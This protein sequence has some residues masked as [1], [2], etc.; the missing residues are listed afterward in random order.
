MAGQLTR[1]NLRDIRMRLYL[2]V[3][4]IFLSIPS[5]NPVKLTSEVL[6]FPEESV[7]ALGAL[8]FLYIIFANGKELSYYAL[9]IFFHS[10]LNIFFSSIEVLGREN[11]PQHGPI[12]FSGNHMNQ[13]VDGGVA[14]I[15]CPHKLNFLVAASSFKMFLIGHFARLLS[16]LP[17]HRPIDNAKQAKGKIY[18]EGLKCFGEGT[19]F[20]K[21]S[22]KDKIRPSNT[23]NIYT[24]VQVESDTVCI[25]GNDKGDPSPIDETVCKGPG[26]AVK[27]ETLSFVD[28]SGTFSEVHTALQK[29]ESII[30][31]P[32]GGSHDNT[33]LLPLK[34]GVASIAFGTLSDGNTNVSIVPFGLN[35]FRGDRFRGKVV[36]EY[37]EPIH[38]TKELAQKYKENKREAYRDLLS[39][40]A[41]GMRS[42]LVT[43]ENYDELK[44]IHTARRLY[45]RAGS[46]AIMTTKARQ[47]LA[48]RFSMALRILKERYKDPSDPDTTVP[49]DLKVLQHKLDEYQETLEKWGIYDYQVN[50]LDISFSK[51]L[52]VFLHGFI[53][54][55]VASIPSVL[56]NLPVGFAAKLFAE[57]KRTEALAKS[58][59]KIAATDVLQSNKIIFSIAA[60]PFLWITYA[61]LLYFF[62]NWQLKTIVLSFL[63]F[64]IF[65]YIGIKS[66]ETSMVDL[67]DLRP[68]FLRLFPSFR[69]QAVKIP[70]QRAEV[71]KLV[72]AA[73]KKYG[74]SMGPLYYQKEPGAWFNTEHRTIAR[75]SS[76]NLLNRM[77]EEH[78]QPNST[79]VRVPS[80]IDK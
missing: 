1:S 55:F 68:A 6:N 75:S 35:Y 20:T 71:Q 72:R 43:A 25:L 27:F 70:L 53:I 44:I 3:I 12:I 76:A 41:D 56:L 31:F 38:I 36:V 47:D 58:R 16:A 34:V 42:T 66:V 11:I 80:G 5:L 2:C 57:R 30:I 19:E 52:Y 29:G 15:T 4:V 14:L 7:G 46:S 64:P 40:V 32:E 21:I 67:K 28:Q 49:A 37:G 69:E 65:S 50:Q 8:A 39:Q 45:Q 74:P 26:N 79:E 77:S 13:F 23:S 9:K 61:M 59:V 48:R 22:S 62:S 63:S 73:V 33:D 10:I 18:F 54:F 17:V 78:T 60:V 24:I 51:S